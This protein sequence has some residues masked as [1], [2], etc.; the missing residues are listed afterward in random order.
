MWTKLKKRTIQY[1][2]LVIF[3]VSACQP[4]A[5]ANKQ[6]KP[7]AQKC[8]DGICSGPENA[9]NCP[10]DCDEEDKNQNNAE[11]PAGEAGPV[12]LGIM[13]HLEGW[14]DELFNEE[15]FNHHARLIREYASLFETYGAKLTWESKETTDASIQWGDNVLKEMEERGHGIGVHAD[16]GGQSDYNC[17]VFDRELRIRK[18]TLESLGVTVRH[19]SGVVSHCDWVT[20]M[21]DAGYSFVSGT[22]A[23]GVMSLPEAMRPEEYRN[24]PSPYACHDTYPEALADRIHPWRMNS[25]MDWIRHDPDG[26]LVMLPA[27]HGL[28]C[29]AE[30][31]AGIGCDQEF[32]LEDI[33]LFFEELDAAVALRD[34]KQINMYYVGWSLGKALDVELMEEWLLRIVPYVEADLVE[35][36]TLPEMYD[37]YTAWEAKGN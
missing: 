11:S 34:P 3:V 17:G 5:P 23:Y 10:E 26:K 15:M 13:V 7:Q 19:A 29:F 4:E 35:W 16:L 24:C 8:G 2:L 25:G 33:D 36:K 21:V 6:P 22:V 9:D 32:T 14:R 30:S 20:A 18:E 31:A 27:S 37:A 28:A 12:Y 1:I